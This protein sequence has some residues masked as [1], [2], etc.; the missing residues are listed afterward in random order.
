MKISISLK[1]SIVTKLIVLIL[2]AVLIPMIII[3]IFTYKN[4]LEKQ[5][6][7]Y[8]YS[9]L[10]ILIKNAENIKNFFEQF[11]SLSNSLILDKTFTKNLEIPKDEVKTMWENEERLRYLL[12]SNPNILGLNLYMEKSDML[13]S[14]PR[15]TNSTIIQDTEINNSDWYQKTIKEDGEIGLI[16]DYKKYIHWSQTEERDQVYTFNRVYRGIDGDLSAVLSLELSDEMFVGLCKVVVQENEIVILTKQD[17]TVLYSNKESISGFES[18]EKENGYAVKSVSG[19]DFLVL[20]ADS[21]ED[22]RLYKLV[23]MSIISKQAMENVMP[24]I[25]TWIILTILVILLVIPFIIVTITRPLA[26]ITDKIASTK[27]GE[28]FPRVMVKGNDEVALLA[29]KFNEM[30][31]NL[32]RVIVSEYKATVTAKNAQIIALQAQIN[33]HFMGNM[34]QSIGNEVISNHTIEA[35]KMLTFL[36]ELLRYGYRAE[37]KKVQLYEEIEYI[38]KY[39]FLQKK[40]FKEHLSF[41]IELDSSVAKKLIPKLVVQPIVENC[42]EHGFSDAQSILKIH[43]KAYKED[44]NV[45]LIVSDNGKGMETGVLEEIKG[46]LKHEKYMIEFS[47][48]LGIRNVFTRLKLIFGESV[49][50][51]IDSKQGEGA[52]F[53]IIFPLK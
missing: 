51:I 13:Y 11:N 29:N 18:K 35:Y 31:Q 47:E 37:L 23:P 53:K 9:D 46:W 22:I 20:F 45:V 12:L 27:N 41:E 21:Y 43:I 25:L 10:E 16:T 32:E 15:Y 30:S 49:S 6:N 44:E 17:G 3:S 1:K 39:L 42:I 50:V 33:P 52:T 26:Q 2:L 34:L 24:G 48:H 19:V 8:I 38:Q 7:E 28:Q 14:I 36:S 40:R 5:K 4:A